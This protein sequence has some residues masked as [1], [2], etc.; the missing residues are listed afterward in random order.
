MHLISWASTSHSPRE[1]ERNVLR[2]LSIFICVKKGLSKMASLFFQILQVLIAVGTDSFRNLFR[3]STFLVISISVQGWE[4]VINTF[5]IL[6]TDHCVSERY[7]PSP[8]WGLKRVPWYFL[9]IWFSCF[10]FCI[11]V[12]RT[13]VQIPALPPTRC[14]NWVKFLQHLRLNIL[15]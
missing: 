8:A 12:G 15:S 13:Q 5:K 11:E 4:C 1:G 14:W 6:E 10:L 3:W 2:S 7:R 9:N